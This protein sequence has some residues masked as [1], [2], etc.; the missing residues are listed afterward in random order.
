MPDGERRA[1]YLTEL[2]AAALAQGQLL[3]FEV[4]GRCMWP[5]LRPGDRVLVR[6]VDAELMLGDVVVYRAAD[7][8]FVHRVL[9]LDHASA[10]VTCRGD[11][12]LARDA[13]VRV[14]ALLGRVVAV[15]R[16]GRRV[17]LPQRA[18]LCS[19]LLAPLRAWSSHAAHDPARRTPSACAE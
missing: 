11:A 5:A 10:S 6:A 17:R 1:R 12:S 13:P 2:S 4:H 14:P 16:A 19:R 18:S 3:A 9:A 8:T 7:R 15:E